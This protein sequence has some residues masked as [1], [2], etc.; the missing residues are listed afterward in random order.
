[1]PVTVSAISREHVEAFI[2]DL[3]ARW[4]P[5]TARNRFQAL[6]RFFAFLAEEGEISDSPMA[7]M[8][9][10]KVPETLAQVVG[11][12]DLRALLQACAGSTFEERRDTALFRVFIDTGAR[13]SE[14]AGLRWNPGDEFR[15]DVDLDQGIL[16][17]TGKGGR[18]RILPIGRRTIRAAG[19]LPPNSEPAPRRGPGVAVALPQGSLEPEWHPPDDAEACRSCRCSTDSPAQL[20]APVRSRLAFERRKRRRLDAPGWVAES[21][22]AAEIRC[23]HR[24]RASE[25]RP[26]TSEP[27]RPAVARPVT[28]LEVLR[29]GDD[30][31]PRGD[32]SRFCAVRLAAK[33]GCM[34]P[35]EVAETIKNP[36]TPSLPRGEMGPMSVR[37]GGG[38]AHTLSTLGTTL[39]S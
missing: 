19:P 25:E 28:C 18:E 13:L 33:G 31:R 9:P 7:R 4:R 5:A 30:S 32:S 27:G 1:M 23:Q 8:R 3:L 39:G 6:Q 12:D 24:R 14:V 16:R 29:L 11:E 26:P 38:S 15:N 17:V 2:E 21:G 36:P 35:S 10:P 34:G 22:D 20:A 37:S